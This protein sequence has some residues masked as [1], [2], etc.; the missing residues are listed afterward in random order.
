MVVA[1]ARSTALFAEGAQFLVAAKA[2][3]T[4]LVADGAPSVVRAD[5]RTTAWLAIIWVGAVAA[6]LA[7]RLGAI[8]ALLWHALVLGASLALLWRVLLLGASLSLLWRALLLGSWWWCYLSFLVDSRA[9]CF[10]FFCIEG[11]IVYKVSFAFR[12]PY[13]AAVVNWGKAC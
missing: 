13:I 11:R 10:P 3:S 9:L 6:L 12:I 8:L 5:A 4:A 2:R 7:L 1:E